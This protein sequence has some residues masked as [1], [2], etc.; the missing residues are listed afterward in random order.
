M[1]KPHLVIATGIYP[2]Q[3]GGPATY[4]KLLHDEI[5]K[6]GWEVSVVNFGDVLRYPKLIRHGVYAFR[7]YKVLRNNSIV[8]A[9]DP[10]SVGL[11]VN[12]IC[13]ATRREYVLKI[14]GDYA[15][16]QG[17]QRYGVFDDLDTFSKKGGYGLK[18]AFLKYIQTY[19]ARHARDIIV[20]SEYLKGIV[21]NWG[22]NPNTIN[23]VYNAVTD[24]DVE[25]TIQ[26][27]GFV[28][29]T[30]GRLVPWKRIDKVIEACS[31]VKD[32][33]LLVAGDGPERDRLENMSEGR[34]IDITFL[35]HLEQKVLWNY[36]KAC[37][38]FILNSS[39]EGLSHILLEVM[40][41]GTPIV[42]SRA[43]GNAEV[44]ED[45]VNGILVD[46][47]DIEELKESIE[48]MKDKDTVSSFVEAGLKK[49]EMFS[50]ENM[51][52]KLLNIL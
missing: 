19:V 27:D 32:A 13:K 11:P 26:L 3:I 12:I 28:V 50:R 29:L 14:V 17:K 34:N 22:V 39:Y 6:R 31:G 23:V 43:G 52:A 42:A 41:I 5:P 37:D 8:Y 20:P 24:I 36:I 40:K 10:V 38:V 48:R 16:E 51:I 25:D 9:Q 46:G 2:P 45:G 15:W 30:A 35:G 49:S 7:L 1:N 21:S 18:V 44:I 4:S 33:R 47:D